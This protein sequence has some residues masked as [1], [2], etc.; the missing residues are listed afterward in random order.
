MIAANSLTFFRPRFPIVFTTHSVPVL[1]SY[2]TRVF[3]ITSIQNQRRRSH[4]SLSLTRGLTHFLSPPSRSLYRHPYAPLWK[5]E[6]T[7]GTEQNETY[8]RYVA[9]AICTRHAQRLDRIIL[10]PNIL[11]W[12][13][14]HL[15]G[16]HMS[17]RYMYVC[18]C[19]HACTCMHRRTHVSFKNMNQ[20]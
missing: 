9:T 16:A 10:G 7:T 1:F 3:H 19:M 6:D 13:T 20:W 4:L 2:D 12:T 8:E 14:E 17:T 18:T 5:K 11:S 15:S